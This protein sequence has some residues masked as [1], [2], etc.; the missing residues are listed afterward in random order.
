[1]S[2]APVRQFALFT[3]VGTNNYTLHIA[4]R[5]PNYVYPNCL[6]YAKKTFTI[7]QQSRLWDSVSLSN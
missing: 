2:M 6:Q 7:T 1:M 5:D 3:S 4:R